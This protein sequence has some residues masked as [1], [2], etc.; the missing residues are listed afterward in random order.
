M[1]IRILDMALTNA[2]ILYRRIHGHEAI[3]CVEFRRV[4]AV[5]YMKCTSCATRKT[6]AAVTSEDVRFDGLNHYMQYR[7]GQRRCQRKDCKSRPKS[8]CLKCD[9]TLCANC[10][11]P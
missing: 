10:F 5:P 4:V 9:V 1:F 7:D 6:K 2:W 8:Y 3:S 11:L